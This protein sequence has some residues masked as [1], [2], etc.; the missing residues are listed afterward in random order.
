MTRAVSQTKPHIFKG[1]L[2]WYCCMKDKPLGLGHTAKAAYD[3]WLYK[4]L[5]A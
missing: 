3:D 4:S 5:R 1:A 2:C